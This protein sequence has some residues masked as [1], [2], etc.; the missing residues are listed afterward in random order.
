[1]VCGRC[2]SS[3]RQSLEE[4]QIEYENV[5][6]GEIILPRALS[7]TEKKTLGA[8]LLK[9]GFELIDNHSGAIIEKIKSTVIEKARMNLRPDEKKLKLS[10]LLS[11]RLNYEY[12]HLSTLFSEVEGRTIENYFIE[13]RIEYAKELIIYGQKNLSEIAFLLDYSSVAH[14]SAQFKKVTG[15]TPTFFKTVGA[16]KRKAIDDV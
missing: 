11:R 9:N 3:V 16:S 10:A 13:Q 4:A 12:S 2:I 14:L 6:L 8:L 5:T 15:L 1:M 7:S